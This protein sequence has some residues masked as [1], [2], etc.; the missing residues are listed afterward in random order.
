MQATYHLGGRMALF[1]II[2]AIIGLSIS[3]SD[4]KQ[5]FSQS[6]F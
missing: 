3:N 4:C 2:S 5:R 6:Q 1:A